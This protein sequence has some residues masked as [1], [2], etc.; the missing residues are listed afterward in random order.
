MKPSNKGFAIPLL[1]LALAILIGLG[2]FVYIQSNTVKTLIPEPVAC[3]EEARQ[4]PDGSYVG[5]TGPNCEF[6][7]S[8]S[9]STEP[10][11][12]S[13]TPSSGP[14]GTIIELKGNNLTGFEGDLD[15]II[16]NSKGETAYMLGM[17]SFTVDKNLIKVKIES[18]ICKQ[19]NSYSG[20][21]CESYLN[22]IPGVYNI[23]TAPWG[24]VSNKMQFT[25]TSGEQMSL[26]VYVQD[27]ELSETKMDCRIT[28][29]V[30]YTVP[31][32]A[33]VADASL[34]ILFENE[35]AEYAVYKS[36]TVS[37]GVAKVM[38]G[39]E[40]MPSGYPINGLSSCESGHLLSVLNDTLTQY[41]TIKS[42][43]LYSP[44]GKIEF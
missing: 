24:K 3:T 15:A 17:N 10:V 20:L 40:N 2:V 31:K 29:K 28:K 6:V 38:L 13:I 4:C 1:I 32:V 25:V 8:V 37:G 43:E 34:K 18:K 5:R 7:C 19:N 36:V 35:L 33:T 39:S 42:V 21:P 44:N 16:E 23:Y 9:T 30:T 22:I 41:P 11:I 27:K 12:K 26:S 14:I